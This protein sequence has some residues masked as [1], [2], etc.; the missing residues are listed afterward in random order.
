MKSTSRPPYAEQDWTPQ[1]K[2][3]AAQVTRLDSDVGRLLK[4]LGIDEN[5]L[6]MLSGDNGSSFA[7]ESEIGRLFDQS[8]GSRLR[9]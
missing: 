1:Q 2:A 6:V 7:A 5:T 9:G 4:E 8:M 3:Y